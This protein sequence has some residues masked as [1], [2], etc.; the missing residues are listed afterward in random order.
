[1]TLERAPLLS[2][3]PVARAAARMA[4]TP[5]KHWMLAQADDV[6]ASYVREVLDT[7]Q[8]RFTNRE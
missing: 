5:E 3:G 8:G 6:R 1:M 7:A 4:Q 2:P